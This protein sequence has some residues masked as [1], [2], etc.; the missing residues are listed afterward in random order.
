MRHTAGTLN[1]TW[2]GILGFLLLVAGALVLLQGTG[3]LQEIVSTPQSG[4]KVLTGELHPFFAQTWVVAV[5]L[6]IG[7][8]LAI[9]A[10][11]WIIAQIPRKHTT[12]RYRLHLDGTQGRTTCDPAVLATAVVDQVNHLPGVVNSSALLRGTAEEPD[13]ALKVTINDGADVREL[14]HQLEATT[15]PNLSTALEAPIQRCRLQLD[16]SARTQQSGTVVHSTGT[17]LQ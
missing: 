17:V 13:L 12:E 14:L 1:R 15:L 5:L 2:L 3:A 8:L 11:A 7:V 9:L 4:A 10:L 16:V 6:V